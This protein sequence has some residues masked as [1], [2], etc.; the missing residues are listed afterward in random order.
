MIDFRS[1]TVTRPTPAM[2]DAMMAAAVGD[3]VFG[4]DPTVNELESYASALF[5]KQAGLFCASGTMANQIAAKV[6]TQPG[7]EVILH[8]LS[9]LYYY[10]VGGLMSNSGLSVCL[11]RGERGMITAADVEAHINPD[12][13]HRP[14][15]A[16]VTVENTMNK[17]GGAVYNNDELARIAQV[18]SNHSLKFHLDGARIFNA[19]SV[20]GQSPAECGALFDSIS[21]CLSKG[22]GAPVGSVLLGD[23]DFIRKARRVR[24]VFGGGMRQAGFLA[25]AGLYAL[26]N[27]TSRLIT[28]HIQAARLGN[29]LAL[30]SW[31]AEVLPV[32]TNILIFKIQPPASAAA[33]VKYFAGH[34]LLCIAVDRDHIRFVTHLDISPEQM[35]EAEAII[36]SVPDDGF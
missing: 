19:M 28:D 34:G 24:K 10:E 20:T 18:C 36:H 35:D 1:D 31:V 29:L 7:D 15:T 22:L 17:G 16:L 25:A 8:G 33:M 2:R 21:V 9:H 27:N 3:D 5:G 14:H 11:L 26:N 30:K 13:L 12:D 4:E 32:E 23:S 6:H